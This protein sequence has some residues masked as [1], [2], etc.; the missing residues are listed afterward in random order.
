MVSK[1]ETILTLPNNAQ[2]RAVGFLSIS[3]ITY[4][5][6]NMAA[7]YQALLDT[8]RDAMGLEEYSF[9]WG[10]KA[11]YSMIV[12]ATPDAFREKGELEMD[13][14][15]ILLGK[16]VL[17]VDDEKDILETLIDL[18]RLCRIDAVTSFDEAK[19]LLERHRYDAAIL[20]IMGVKGFDLLEMAVAKN[21]PALMLTAHSLNE[22]SLM[23][24]IKE[25]AA[26]YVPK[27]EIA[28]ID[29]YLADVLEAR[30]KNKNPWARWINRLGS[31]FDVLFTG[32][33]WREQQRE[34]LKKI[35]KAKW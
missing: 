32:P 7:H 4:S 20:D 5:K 30:E 25:G 27:N 10:T 26:Y 16:K 19:G 29:I 9:L 8:K 6:L 1:N 17:I 23:K 33:K 21:V 11:W 14:K 24:S 34:F 2:Y 12:L 28:H 22:E 13:T 18:L 35:D 31:T 3:L 15:K